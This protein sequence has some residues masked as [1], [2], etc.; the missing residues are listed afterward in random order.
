MLSV[1][2]YFTTRAA[3]NVSPAPDKSYTATFSAGYIL[4]LYRAPLAPNVTIN[5]SAQS[6][7][8][9]WGFTILYSSSLIFIN[10]ALLQNS[11][12]HFLV[13]IKTFGWLEQI[14]FILCHSQQLQLRPIFLLL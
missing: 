1:S 3:W 4:P 7:S 13:S 12:K 8:Q 6:C 2:K 10:L 11:S 14:N 5:L 9:M